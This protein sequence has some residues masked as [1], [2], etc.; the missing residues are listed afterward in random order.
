ME[1]PELSRA[2]VES[3]G[4]RFEEAL[5][6]ALNTSQSVGLG[7]VAMLGVVVPLAGIGFVISQ[8]HA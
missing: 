7:F 6:S 5:H 4:I 8:F 3:F 2:A 1:S